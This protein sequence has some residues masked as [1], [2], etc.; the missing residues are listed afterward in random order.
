MHVIITFHVEVS[1]SRVWAALRYTTCMYGVAKCRGVDYA[2][3][4]RPITR[5]IC[6][7]LAAA[8][9]AFRRRPDLGPLSLRGAPATESRRGQENFRCVETRLF[10]PGLFG[11][12][13]PGTLKKKHAQ[14]FTQTPP[15]TNGFLLY[16]HVGARPF[17]TAGAHAL[18]FP[19]PPAGANSVVCNCGGWW[20]AVSA[21]TFQTFRL[22][23]HNNNLHSR[24]TQ[25]FQYKCIQE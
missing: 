7:F 16:P 15:H 4:L 3:M 9:A 19:A 13:R 5:T 1:G 17:G 6:R 11:L 22:S 24:T 8:A 2:A 25:Y 18:A 14:H 20:W 12:F 23:L 21:P 10:R